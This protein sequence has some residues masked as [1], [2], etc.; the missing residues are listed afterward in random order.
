MPFFYI[1]KLACDHDSLPRQT[2]HDTV[3][4]SATTAAYEFL[5]VYCVDLWLQ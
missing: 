2:C 1:G 4:N 3:G 5:P